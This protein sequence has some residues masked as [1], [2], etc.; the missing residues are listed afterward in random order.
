MDIFADFVKV[1]TTTTGTGT[2]SLGSAPSGFNDFSEVADGSSVTIQI[3]DN[4]NSPSQWEICR[5][6]YTAGSPDTLSRGTLFSSSTGSRV[7]FAS[8]TKFVRLVS[9]EEIFNAVAE[10]LDGTLTTGGSSGAYTL[11]SVRNV[12]S[13]Y[14]GLMVMFKV[15]HA[16]PSGGSTF[17]LNSIGAT[18]LYD[19]DGNAIVENALVTGKKYL[20]WSDGTYFYVMNSGASEFID[21]TTFSDPADTT[22][23]A[24]LDCGSIT[25]G[26][27]RVLTVPDTDLT[28]AGSDVEQTWTQNQTYDGISYF[29]SFSVTGAT[30]GKQIFDLLIDSSRD[31]TT[32]APHQRFYNPN[33]LTGGINTNGSS[34]IFAT[35][36]DERLK[37]N[38]RDFDSDAIIRAIKVYEYQWKADGTKGF[39]PKAQE[40]H[41]VFPAAVVE[42][43]SGDNPGDETFVPWGYDASTLVPLLI[44]TVQ[45]LL[46]RVEALEAK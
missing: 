11:Q 1:T 44:R 21:S 32:I 16:S 45:G 14:D 18:A 3:I 31:V 20:A 46:D 35:S 41:P 24:R 43:S 37:E 42:G 9:T 12:S 15:N 19:A 26:T 4:P 39:G 5:S 34:T 30:S 28:V 13:L 17:N 29:G 22:K 38:F 36:S 2:L 40:L 27:T 7:N 8:G 6:T 10:T 23:K 25:T 33:G